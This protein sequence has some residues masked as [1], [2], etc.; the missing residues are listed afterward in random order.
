M[1]KLTIEKVLEV[2]VYNSERDDIRL[3][4]I[5]PRLGWSEEGGLLGAE[6]ANG[7][8]HRLPANCRRTCGKDRL[9][10]SEFGLLRNETVRTP[11]GVG[12]LL[13]TLPDGSSL[14]RLDWGFGPDVHITGTFSAKNVE[15]LGRS[16]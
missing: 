4:S 14:V 2:F 5:R 1:A 3:A 16:S 8:L 11:E 6:L 12:E 9:T 7:I 15:V 13:Q 10:A